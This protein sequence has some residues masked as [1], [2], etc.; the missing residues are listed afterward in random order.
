MIVIDFLRLLRD[1]Y[2]CV[3]RSKEGAKLLPPSNSELRRWC[4]KNGVLINGKIV[5]ATDEVPDWH[6]WQLTFF[7]KNDKARCSVVW[8]ETNIITEENS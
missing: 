7:P 6:V 4:K 2:K 8:E 5:G 1:K 3:P